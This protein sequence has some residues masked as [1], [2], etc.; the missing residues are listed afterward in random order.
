[1]ISLHNFQS[2][3]LLTV[4]VQ[5][6]ICLIIQFKK[7]IMFNWEVIAAERSFCNSL[8]RSFCYWAIKI[9]LH[10]IMSEVGRSFWSL[11]SIDLIVLENIW[12]IFKKIALSIVMV[13]PWT[14][15]YVSP[16]RY[17]T[18]PQPGEDVV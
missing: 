18:P 1:M 5:Y 9:A 11:I 15:T 3:I 17:K 6:L 14:D 2:I 4:N 10:A 8:Y 16:S 7:Q 12:A 13:F